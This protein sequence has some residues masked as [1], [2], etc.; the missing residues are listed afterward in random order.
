MKRRT[1]IITLVISIVL[2]LGLVLSYAMRTV[3]LWRAVSPPTVKIAGEMCG[4]IAGLV[5]PQG[6]VC[7][8]EE[9]AGII[10][11]AGVCKPQRQ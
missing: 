1:I 11:N 6:F 8:M 2:V 7:I 5:C 3:R 4:G 10:D 9:N